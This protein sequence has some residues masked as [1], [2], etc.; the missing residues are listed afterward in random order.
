MWRHDPALIAYQ[1]TPGAMASEPRVLARHSLGATPGAA[2]FADLLGSGREAE[3]LVPDGAR[4]AAC[5]AA[6]KRFRESR[7]QGDVLDLTA[8]SGSRIARATGRTRSLP[9]P[10]GWAAPVRRTSSSTAGPARRPGRGRP[11]AGR[12]R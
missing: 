4:L 12:G 1:P 10:A 2:T 11:A 7:P 8:W 5:A 6:A 9:S 3:V